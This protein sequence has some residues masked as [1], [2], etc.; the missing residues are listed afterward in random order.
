MEI[1]SEKVT[2]LTKQ[3]ISSGL[4]TSAGFFYKANLTSEDSRKTIQSRAV[5]RFTW[6]DPQY[7][8][9]LPALPCYLA[10]ARNAFWS[11][12]VRVLAATRAAGVIEV[13]IV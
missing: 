5:I 2:N 3:N 1:N 6:L 8:K 11:M 4:L 12:G 9:N 7:L 10:C 13:S